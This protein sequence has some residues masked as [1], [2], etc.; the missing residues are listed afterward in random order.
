MTVEDLLTMRTGHEKMT[1]GSVW[2]RIRTSWV[3]EFFKIPVVHRPG[4]VFVYTSAASY[5]LSAI[6]TKTTG[7]TLVEYLTPRFFEPL[8]ITG[9]QWDVGPNNI[10]PG[11]NGLS[12]KTSDSLKLGVLHLNKGMWN[13]RR[14]LPEDW[15]AAVQAQHVPGKYGYQWWLGPQG[16]SYGNGLFSQ[17]SFVFPGQDAVLAMTSA[18]KIGTP[19][20]QRIFGHFPKAFGDSPASPEGGKALSKRLASLR[21]APPHKATHSSTAR[22]V[23]GKTFAAQ[24]NEDGVASLRFDFTPKQCRFTLADAR[25]EHVI[26]AGLGA[27]VEGQ[28]TMTGNKLHHEYQPASMRVVADARWS[29]PDTLVMTWTFVESAFRDTVVCRF[30]G[31]AVTLD[32]S[33]NV[34]SGATA[35]ATLKAQMA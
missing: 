22:R 26:A 10:S 29:D 33:V 27:P 19:F 30:D 25:G 2:R 7:Q 3:A 11:A 18:V 23:S 16:I 35:L 1:P 24:A 12:W 17:Y 28:T 8:D 6:I 21:L 15:V 34:N 13:G 5:M 20:P 4:T 9:F 31:D 14:V 32:R